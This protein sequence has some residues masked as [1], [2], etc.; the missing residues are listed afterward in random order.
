MER[1][2]SYQK[3]KRF[4]EQRHTQTH[5]NLFKIFLQ[6]QM[7][8]SMLRKTSMTVEILLISFRV[9]VCAFAPEISSIFGK[10]FAFPFCYFE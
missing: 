7:S 3:L 8:F 10:S 6:S 2:N 1:E 4:P 5:G 9:F